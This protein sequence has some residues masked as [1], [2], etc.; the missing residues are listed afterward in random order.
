MSE[1][2]SIVYATIDV[3][4]IKTPHVLR[5]RTSCNFSKVNVTYTSAYKQVGRY[6]LDTLS[7]CVYTGDLLPFLECGL[8]E[9]ATAY[10]SLYYYK[11]DK[12][13]VEIEAERLIASEVI[14][15]APMVW[16]QLKYEQRQGD[17]ANFIRVNGTNSITLIPSN[18]PN[19]DVLSLEFYNSLRKRH[20]EILATVTRSYLECE[21]IHC[22]NKDLEVTIILYRTDRLK[23]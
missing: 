10:K 12:R 17:R 6:L 8:M 23:K 19:W 13:I 18:Y 16:F 11:G 3:Q 2:D 4:D 1:E 7:R 20:A 9:S 22:S 21:T 5:Y 14:R 15:C